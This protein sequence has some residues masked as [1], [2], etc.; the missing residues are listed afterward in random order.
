LSQPSAPPLSREPV[1]YVVGALGALLVYLASVIPG[2]PDNAET[3]IQGFIPAI[4][5]VI[6]S[7]RAASISRPTVWV[8]GI[9]AGIFTIL[10]GFGVDVNPADQTAIQDAVLL[11]VAYLTRQNTDPVVPKPTT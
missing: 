8:G 6:A 3:I 11:I 1:M 2:L 7:F 10:I 9:I 5:G 4:L